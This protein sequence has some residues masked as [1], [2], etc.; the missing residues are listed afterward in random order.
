MVIMSKFKDIDILQYIKLNYLSKRVLH[1]GKGKIIPFHGAH[2]DLEGNSKLIVHDDSLEFGLN[3][4]KGSKAETLVRLRNGAVWNA[5]GYCGLSY[6]TTIEINSNAELESGYF[7][8]NSNSVLVVNQ[9]MTVGDD[10]MLGR[11]VVIYDSDFHSLNSKEN[12]SELV[13]IGD[14]V[15]IATNSIVL[16]GVHIGNGSVIAAG[17]IVSEDVPERVVIGN[18]TKQKVLSENAEWKR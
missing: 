10:V 17:A 9:A 6:G 11:N 7:T 13:V 8:V 1:E 16:K 4:I 5:K 3:K 14:H 2:V 15:W 12:V 18:G